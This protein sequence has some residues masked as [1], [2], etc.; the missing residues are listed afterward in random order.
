V[1]FFWAF[2]SG[3]VK[4]LNRPALLDHLRLVQDKIPGYEK[5]LQQLRI[6]AN[7]RNLQ[8]LTQEITESITKYFKEEND[9]L[10]QKGEKIGEQRGEQKKEYNFIVN[11]LEETDFSD[12]KIAALTDADL[13]LVRQ[14]REQLKK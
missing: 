14:I 9:F 3:K 7:L 11:L 8:S 2:P 6:L 5:H 4:R 12:E 13:E 1:V 10:Y